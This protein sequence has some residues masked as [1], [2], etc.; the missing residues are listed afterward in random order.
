[1]NTPTDVG[2]EQWAAS[3]RTRPLY[4]ADPNTPGS[5]YHNERPVGVQQTGWH[6]VAQ[7]R[8]WL[9]DALGGVVWFGVDDTA[10]SVHVPFYCGIE[11]VPAGWADE[12]IQ[13]TDDTGAGL[14]VDFD[15]AFWVFNLVA[16]FVY[17]R[18]ADA[19]VL[20][21]ERIVEEE[22]AFF[23]AVAAN[24]AKVQLAIKNGAQPSEV[25]ALLTKFSGDHGS[26]LL[27]RWNAL[28]KA[29]FFRFRD[30]FTVSPPAKQPAGSKDHPWADVNQ[31]G[32][33]AAW[34]A[35]VIKDTGDRFKV[36]ATLEASE[37]EMRKRQIVGL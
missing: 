2:A 7:M 36:P 14:T 31:Q 15:K 3:V 6:F 22:G 8:R 35:R 20:V 32:M 19:H 26:A 4:W 33:K 25:A 23:K 21:Q 37:N 29:L 1:M 11:A 17:G 18:W 5:Q 30:Y 16:N 28:W 13:H 24:D 27:V 12:G 10:H 34:R 9:P